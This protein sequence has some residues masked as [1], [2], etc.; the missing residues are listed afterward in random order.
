MVVYASELVERN[1]K[2]DDKM[3]REVEFLRKRIGNMDK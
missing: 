1:M 2:A 3:R